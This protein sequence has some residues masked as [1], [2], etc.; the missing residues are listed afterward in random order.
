M[1]W[2]ETAIS[3]KIEAAGNHVILIPANSPTAPLDTVDLYDGITGN[4]IAENIPED[5]ARA[6]AI[7]WNELVDSGENT[8]SIK[9]LNISWL[10]EKRRGSNGKNY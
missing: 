4:F 9:K 2:F 10:V 7:I 3:E 6:F 5:S 8:E 1:N